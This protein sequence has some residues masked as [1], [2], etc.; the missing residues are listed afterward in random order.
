VNTLIYGF[1]RYGWAAVIIALLAFFLTQLTKQPVK[2]LTLKITH[3][4]WQKLANKSILLLPLLWGMA[5]W[6]LYVYIFKVQGFTAVEICLAGAV[7][8]AMAIILYGLVGGVI[9]GFKNPYAS[10][11]G[12]EV[13]DKVIDFITTKTVAAADADEVAPDSP[14]EVEQTPEDK[15]VAAIKAVAADASESLIKKILD[16]LKTKKQ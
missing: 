3:A 11:E 9:K 12:A 2:N 15:A 4:G 7:A 14:G 6:A 16:N 8:G 1:E 13:A 10:G 5:L